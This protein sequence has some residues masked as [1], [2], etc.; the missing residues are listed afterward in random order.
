MSNLKY[1]DD[2]R[3]WSEEFIRYMKMIVTSPQYK[4][5][6]WAI[7]D[8]KQIR[9]NAPSNRPPGGKWSDLHD[10]R[11][12]WWKRK[13]SEVG[14]KIEG[15]W[16]SEVAKKI[17]PTGEKPCQTCG[18]TMLLSYVYP[19]RNTIN[20]INKHLPDEDQLDFLEFKTIYEIVDYL[21][22]VIPDKALAVLIEIFPDIPL[23]IKTKESVSKY[24]E[25][26]VV[27]K[28]PKGKLSPG[29]M[30]NAPDRL[31]GFHTY[32]LCCRSKQDTGRNS[33]N[34]R[35]Y[36][37]DRRA[38][39]Q[40]CEGNWAAANLLMNLSAD[41]TCKKCGKY[42]KI[43]ADHIGP[44]SL[45]FAHTP[46]FAPMCRGCNSG[47]NNRMSFSDIQALLELENRGIKVISWQAK[48][49][50]D[51]CKN[52]VSN[53]N[54]ALLLSKLLRINQ[55]HYLELLY[56][57]MLEKIPDVLLQ[58]LN[59]SYVKYKYEFIDLDP[60]NFTFTKIIQ[61]PR[62]STYVKSKSARMTRIAFEALRDYGS[63]TKRNIQDIRIDQIQRG[64][65]K[66]KEDIQKAKSQDSELRR[67]LVRAIEEDEISKRIES[68]EAI[69]RI[70][71]TSEL[72]FNY[73]R[74]GIQ[75]LLSSIAIVLYKRF[76]EN[77]AIRRGD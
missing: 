67:K 11:L 55:H 69:F 25:E 48:G 47:K 17:H 74:N 2:R 14:I 4:G 28:E 61:T 12:E 62:S 37:D 44:I 34:L 39:E 15:H 20:K 66:L 51:K 50:W 59:T 5:M 76:E 7:D 40:W 42:T 36:T 29:A 1:G 35:T 22:D 57:M 41:G 71:L 60:T 19:T 31:D 70:S 49:L 27:P 53:D 8:E 45:G 65:E 56:I 52:E 30:S 10:E 38:F 54:Q 21:F 77:R 13:A 72:N 3:K 9:W 33:A 32:N 6:P 24:L 16:I 63:K 73:I 26:E 64:Y 58:F 75:E 18:K 68:L 46:Y 43:T 23:E